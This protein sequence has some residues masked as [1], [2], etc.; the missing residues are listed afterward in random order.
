MSETRITRQLYAAFANNELSKWDDLVWENVLLHS[1]LGRD[2]KG[3]EA[4]KNWAFQFLKAF[5]PR[6]DL[7]DEFQ[8]GDRALFTVNIYWKHVDNF[9]ELTPSGRSGTSVE[10]FILTLREGKVAKWE[11]ADMTLDLILYLT[12][13]RGWVYPQNVEP[14]PIVKGEYLRL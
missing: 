8:A 14:V 13:E 6:L 12:R 1:P 3:R 7:V 11:V 5:R 10:V 4:L 9:F 2:I